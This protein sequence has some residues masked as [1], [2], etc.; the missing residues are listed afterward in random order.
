MQSGRWQ[1]GYY[2]VANVFAL[3]LGMRP[4]ELAF[5]ETAPRAHF[6]DVVFNNKE[7]TMFPHTFKKSN[8]KSTFFN[9]NLKN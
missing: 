1:C 2:A 7:I 6:I 4:E 9:I 3:L 8:Q 5:N